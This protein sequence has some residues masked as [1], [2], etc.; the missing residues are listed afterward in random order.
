MSHEITI[1]EDGSAEAAYALTPAWHGLGTV[2]NHAMTSE[3]AIRLAR[4]DWAVE[5]WP[6]AAGKRLGRMIP[7]PDK[8]ANVRT[9]SHAVLGVVSRQYEVVQNT[10]AFEFVDALHQDGIIKYEAAGSLKGGRL[11]W[12][13]ARMPQEFEVAAGDALRKYI[14]FSTSHDGSRAVRCL[15]TSVRV[16]CWNTYTMATEDEAAGVTIRHM[17]DLDAKLAEARRAVMA[18]EGAFDEYHERARVLTEARVDPT[19]MEAYVNVLFPDEVGRHNWHRE[20]M[21]DAILAAFRD[22]PQMVPSIQGTAW[23]AFNAVTQVVDHRS[24]YRARGMGGSAENRM[25]ST[26]L[27]GNARLKKSAMDLAMASF[28]A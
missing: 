18:V 25:I 24:V 14:L 13:L 23:A 20:R 12:L 21:R 6:L 19:K 4:L 22:G 11:V 5:Q 2:V 17:G 26:M 16:V 15:P 8:V 28:T 10:E 7:V 9:D 27:G 3:E 1:R